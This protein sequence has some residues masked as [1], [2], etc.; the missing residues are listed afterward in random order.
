MSRKRSLS[1]K[2]IKEPEE[3]KRVCV[4][5]I[6][7]IPPFRPLHLSIHL[8]GGE[9]PKLPKFSDDPEEEDD[10]PPVPAIPRP[11]QALLLEKPETTVKRATS[12]K[13]I[14]TS[15]SSFDNGRQSTDTEMTMVE[16]SWRPR[17]SSLSYARL[18]STS[19]ASARS[20]QD[21][22]EMLNNPLPPL[23][24]Q[25]ILKP[26]SKKSSQEN[27]KLLVTK[28]VS[29]K[30]SREELKVEG[31]PTLVRSAS[32]QNKRLQTHLQEREQVDVGSPDCSTIAEE[33]SPSVSA[34]SPKHSRRR[35]SSCP[36]RPRQIDQSTTTTAPAAAIGLAIIPATSNAG[37]LATSELIGSQQPAPLDLAPKPQISATITDFTSLDPLPAMMPDGDAEDDNE[38]L[39]AAGFAGTR[40]RSSSDAGSTLLNT[41][42]LLASRPPTA[43]PLGRPG[44]SNTTTTTAT[45][46]ALNLQKNNNNSEDAKDTRALNQLQLNEKASMSIVGARLTQW[47]TRS[48]SLSRESLRPYE[49]TNVMVATAGSDMGE[50][51]WFDHRDSAL[52]T[53]GVVT[54]HPVTTTTTGHVGVDTPVGGDD[55]KS[56]FSVTALAKEIGLGELL[57]AKLGITHPAP[58]PPPPSSTTV[59]VDGAVPTKTILIGEK[60]VEV[61]VQCGITRSRSATE[62]TFVGTE[63]GGSF[64]LMRK[65]TGMGMGGVGKM[66]DGVGVEVVEIERAMGPAAVVMGTTGVDAPLAGVGMA[67]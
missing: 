37:I 48:K 25:I 6:P 9:L 11:P 46:T 31:K 8:P 15:Q 47:L 26:T 66:G 56:M 12:R 3:P 60:E 27:V 54:T 40:N 5:P 42:D 23:P 18:R 58:L 57:D 17:A 41:P 30:T 20:N 50:K 65:G 29:K 7:E 4:S 1:R 39:P 34:M 44:V 2:K 52:I 22:L 16:V 13:S 28:P 51:S 19:S 21:F 24:K 35:S 10:I 59:T 43:D 32:D 33:K 63:R 45:V 38:P 49:N 62:S 55:G 61:K 64:D 14:L 67:M 36:P 53:T